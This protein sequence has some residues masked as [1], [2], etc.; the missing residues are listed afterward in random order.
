M[1][2]GGARFHSEQN[3]LGHCD[4]KATEVPP[5]ADP[6]ASLLLQKAQETKN[7]AQ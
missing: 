6:T 2:P 1:Q 5:E 3:K 4:F 7:K